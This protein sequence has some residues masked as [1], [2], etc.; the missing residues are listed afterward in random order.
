MMQDT[1]NQPTQVPP[2]VTNPLPAQPSQNPKSGINALQHKKKEKGRDVGD[3]ERRSYNLWYDLIAQLVDSDDE[4]EE[5]R[6]DKSDGECSG[7]SGEDEAGSEEDNEEGSDEDDDESEEGE[8]NEDWLSR[9]RRR[10]EGQDR[11]VNNPCGLPLIKPGKKDNGSTPQVLLGRP[12]LKSGGF[13][14]N[15]HNEIFTFE[16]GNTIEIFHLDD[17]SEPEK[18]GLHQ[19]WQDKKNKKKKR[20]ARKRKK[21]EKEEADKKG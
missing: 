8:G 2:P 11:R 4:E 16:V 20:E 14:L 12:F 1:T 10:C 3:S 5:E 7:E 9:N 17:S 18:K 15:Y 6:E 21:R 13:K 19:M